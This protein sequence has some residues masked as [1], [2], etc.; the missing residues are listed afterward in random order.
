MSFSLIEINTAQHPM[1]V[2]ITFRILIVIGVNCITSSL[3]VGSESYCL[4]IAISSVQLLRSERIQL[5]K[6]GLPFSVYSDAV[7][8]KIYNTVLIK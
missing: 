8:E 5:M 7:A 3:A 1:S 4:I 2:E 6:I